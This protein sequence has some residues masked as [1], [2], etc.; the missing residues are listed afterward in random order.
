MNRNLD[1]SFAEVSVPAFR[2][3]MAINGYRVH[4]H[5][6]LYDLIDIKTNALVI[7]DVSQEEAVNW[8][9]EVFFGFKP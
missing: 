2:R 4:K 1:D 5:G 8:A 7:A 3:R 9:A 6:N